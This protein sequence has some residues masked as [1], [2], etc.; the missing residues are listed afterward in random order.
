MNHLIVVVDLLIVGR[1]SVD[2]RSDAGKLMHGVRPNI[3]KIKTR[4]NL[5]QL[6]KF[7]S[8]EWWSVRARRLV[9]SGFV[10]NLHGLTC[11]ASTSKHIFRRVNRRNRANVG[12]VPNSSSTAWKQG[13]IVTMLTWTEKTVDSRWIWTRYSISVRMSSISI[14]FESNPQR[15]L[16]LD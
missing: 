13:S 9:N 2:R 10:L 7:L 5:H 16:E 11:L 8:A 12:R 15:N 1:R 14:L 4:L 3:M 6:F